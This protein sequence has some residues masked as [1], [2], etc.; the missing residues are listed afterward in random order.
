MRA[1]VVALLRNRVRSQRGYAAVLVAILFPVVFVGLAALA[2]DTAR[3]YVEVQ[4]VQNA[5]D[6]GALA[7]VIYMPQDLT[8]ATTTAKAVTARNGYADGTGSI[9]VTVERGTASTQLKV[10]VSSTISNAFGRAIG[11]PTTTISRSST[12]NYTGPAPMGSPCNTFGNEPASG[13]GLSAGPVGTAQGSSPYANCET[14]PEF[15]AVIEGPGT[16]KVWGDR[17]STRQCATVNPLQDGCT[18]ATNNDLNKAG[19]FWYIRVSPNMVAASKPIN[20]QLYDPAF[21]QTG[22]DCSYLPSASAFTAGM[23]PYVGTDAPTRYSKSSITASATQSS[24]CTGDIQP[25]GNVAMTTSF[26]VRMPTDTANPLAGT[27]V[28]GC[29]KQYGT[30]GGSAL[31]T[32]A[33]LNQSSTGTTAATSY[34]VNLAQVF[35]NWTSL[36]TFTPTVAGD[37][38][39]QVRTNVPLGGTLVAN[40]AGRPSFLSSENSAVDDVDGLD[41]TGQGINAFGIRAVVQNT[42]EKSVAVSGYDRMP[43]WANSTAASSTFNL[44]RVLPGARSQFVS[45]QAYDLGDVN[46]NSGGTVTGTVTIKRPTDATGSIT[47]TPF[48]GGCRAV[49]GFAGTIGS[50]SSSC[51]F[52]ISNAANNGKLETFSVPIPSDYSCASTANSGCWYQVE[53]KFDA[54]IAVNDVTTWNAQIVGDP[55]RIIR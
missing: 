6:A 41:T 17:Y 25:D 32:A 48:P 44:I 20:V 23:N 31:P 38:Y 9:V 1:R 21:V 16:K 50:T 55:V 42:F 53:I 33:N 4:R 26:D 36:C 49:G 2:V 27:T 30:F 29:T 34:D 47:T 46:A 28:S 37:Y 18:G 45:F 19:Y 10:T 7:G 35:H 3:W 15:W 8:L 39:L 54:G 22:Q 14:N 43:I 51:T 40:T 52:S 11:T 24:F 13:G 5:A 12:T